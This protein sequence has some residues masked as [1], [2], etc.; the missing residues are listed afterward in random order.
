MKEEKKWWRGGEVLV[1]GWWSTIANGEQEWKISRWLLSL[2]NKSH[3]FGT[4][5]GQGE[6]NLRGIHCVS[7]SL[8]KDVEEEAPFYFTLRAS[9]TNF[10]NGL[11]E[12]FPVSS[13]GSKLEGALRILARCMFPGPGRTI[14]PL[15]R[16]I[17]HIHELSCESGENSR[18]CGGSAPSCGTVC[19]ETRAVGAEERQATGIKDKGDINTHREGLRKNWRS[20]VTATKRG[21]IWTVVAWGRMK[22]LQK[23]QGRTDQMLGAMADVLTSVAMPNQHWVSWKSVYVFLMVCESRMAQIKP[24]TYKEVFFRTCRAR[25]RAHVGAMSLHAKFLS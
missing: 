8:S 16:S 18:G 11:Q 24:Q 4:L 22:A 5:T 10:L 1:R 7:S 20:E 9:W 2:E 12:T 25:C 6:T 15:L 23:N 19:C 13:P 17:T 3:R 14:L 21:T